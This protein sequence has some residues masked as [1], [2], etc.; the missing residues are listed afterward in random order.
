VIG[1]ETLRGLMDFNEVLRDA[2]A[3]EGADECL[4]VGDRGIE[5]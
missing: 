2:H 5:L 3:L 1:L 4:G